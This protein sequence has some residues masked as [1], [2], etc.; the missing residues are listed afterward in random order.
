MHNNSLLRGVG[1]DAVPLPSMLESLEGRVLLA[2]ARLAFG[3]DG[4]ATAA[5]GGAYDDSGTAVAH[6]SDGKLVVA[7]LTKGSSSSV[8][9]ILVARLD[10]GGTLDRTF[11][12]Q[13][14]FQPGGR[15]TSSAAFDVAVQDDGRIVVAGKMDESLGVLRLMPDGRWDRSFGGNGAVVFDSLS[16]GYANRTYLEDD[17]DIVL[18]GD[19]GGAYGY[20]PAIVRLH[21]DGSPDA[22][23]GKGGVRSL[24]VERTGWHRVVDVAPQ[25][26]GK[27]VLLGDAGSSPAFGLAMMRLDA[28]GRRDASFGRGGLVTRPLS[29]VRG[30]S[31]AL[32]VTED[33]EIVAV[34][35]IAGDIVVAKYTPDG[36]PVRAF[37]KNG[38]V[39]TDLG[40]EYDVATEVTTVQDGRLLLLAR[41]WRTGDGYPKMLLRFDARGQLDETFGDGGKLVFET[42]YATNAISMGVA[43]DGSVIVLGHEWNEGGEVKVTRIAGEAIDESYG[44]GG[45][46]T[47]GWRGK[48]DAQLLQLLEAPDGKLYAL[49]WVAGAYSGHPAV[50]RFDAAGRLDPSFNNDGKLVFRREH[51]GGR[52]AL[53]R[54]GRLLFTTVR[55]DD[56]ET[57]IHRFGADGTPD[58]IFGTNGVAVI[59]GTEFFANDIEFDDAGRI[60]LGGGVPRVMRSEFGLMRL[61][62][63]GSPDVAF[64]TGGVV[65]TTM[66]YEAGSVADVIV[67]DDGRIVAIGSSK[68]IFWPTDS[69]NAGG[70][71]AVRYEADGALDTSFHD[72][73][74]IVMGVGPRQEADGIAGRVL[75]DGSIMIV[76]A[77]AFRDEL[78]LAKL[79][80]DG[81][82]DE[83]FGK[84][85]RRTFRPGGYPVGGAFTDDGS[86]L[87]ERE[88]DGGAGDRIFWRIGSDGRR[89]DA[90]GETV[91][92]GL[93]RG[94][95]F[96]WDAGGRLLFG[97]SL[98]GRVAIARY[99]W[100]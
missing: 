46:A 2:A 82:P 98:G 26:D 72:D 32:H 30:R 3:S 52:I 95:G 15:W 42:S 67:Q 100:Q 56:E 80:P 97:G 24:N 43:P 12:K 64:G 57:V 93:P 90:F 41:E 69:Y 9:R 22:A 27:I 40:G 31:T 48:R 25:R 77:Y 7:G 76:G 86:L 92:E 91:I 84:K 21:R 10:H 60:L 45:S 68:G 6:Q 63:D 35:D 78:I 20:R 74:W 18:A 70:I 94:G 55:D 51:Q 11:G 75:E 28:D 66:R 79:K 38:S 85:G 33:D 54:E 58:R 44:T 96:R 73:G 37:G 4:W 5:F 39:V 62:P 59:S 99:V 89:D 34:G 47:F 19:V 53:D 61:L 36:K 17:G 83:A 8:G 65:I 88:R 23:F 13:G 71:A 81:S 50:A 87:L 16:D 1:W 29:P 14:F 49:A